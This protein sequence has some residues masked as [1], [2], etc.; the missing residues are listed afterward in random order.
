MNEKQSNGEETGSGPAEL[1]PVV[2]P[3]PREALDGLDAGPEWEP[4]PRDADAVGRTMFDTPGSHDNTLT[5][6]LP[7]DSLNRVPAQSLVRIESRDDERTYLAIVTAGPFAEP[8]GLRADAPTI[9]TTTVRGATAFMPRYHGRVSVEILG[10]R[11]GYALTPPRFRPLPNSPVFLLDSA[12]SRE[13]LALDGNL[14]LGVAAGDDSLVIN[15]PADKKAVLPRHTG[16]L[17]TTGGGKSTT[18]SRLI[19]QAQQQGFAII[20]LD[21]EGEYTCM[22]AET[23]DPTMLALL[24]DREEEPHGVVGTEL[25]HLAGKRT[26]NPAHGTQK[27]FDLAFERFSPYIVE[28]LLEMSSA[29]VERFTEAYEGAKALLRELNI[30]PRKDDVEEKRQAIELNEF[31][32]GYPRM[33]LDHVI[34]VV[35]CV[36][37]S[38]Y[39]VELDDSVVMSSEFRQGAGRAKLKHKAEQIGSQLGAKV[40]WRALLGHLHRLRRLQVFDSAESIDYEA[41]LEPGRVSIFDLSDSDSPQVNNLVIADVL[42]GVQDCQDAAYREFERDG[43]PSPT[44]VLIIIEEAH[45]FLSDER[46]SKMPYLF[47][48]VARIAKRGRKRWLGLVFVTQLPRHLPPQVLGLVNNWVLHRIS[49]ADTVSRLRRSV[50]GV[51]EA[52]WQRLPGLAPG[53]AIV[54]FTSMTRPLLAAIDPTPA[55]LRMLD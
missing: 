13:V 36:H 22:D 33:R 31:E 43:G 5:V 12:E 49:D 18:V 6:L 29:Q 48:Q 19:D 51:D 39:A 37:D 11:R 21:T 28:E 55:K 53:Q 40:S 8:D 16:I 54:S 41:L 14:R 4:D 42:R 23:E 15:V 46:V 7:K 47:Q 30:F 50:A 32:M 9:V 44:P 27:A 17:G 26:S 3:I 52:L 34:D 20:L 35:R 24:A 25:Y 10:E 38:L 2:A 45:E 1:G